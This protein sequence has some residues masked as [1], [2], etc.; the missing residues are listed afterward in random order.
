[1]LM[2]KKTEKYLRKYLY[3]A[4]IVFVAILLFVRS[5]FNQKILTENITSA[6]SSFINFEFFIYLTWSV[7]FLGL[8]IFLKRKFEN[9]FYPF[10]IWNFIFILISFTYN[11]GLDLT[12]EGW[13]LAKSWGFFHGNPIEN[14]DLIWGS[15]FINGLWLLIKHDPSVLWSRIGFLFFIP[16]NGII[17]Y[18]IL[19][20]FHN[21]KT[22]FISTAVSFLFFYRFYLNYSVINYYYLPVFSILISFLFLIKFH[23]NTNSR[24]SVKYLIISAVFS[25]FAIHLKFTFILIVPF[26]IIYLYLFPN[27]NRFRSMLLYYS[28]MFSAVILGFLIL[29]ILGGASEL[30][31]DSTRLSIM[32]MFKTV[33]AQ[34]QVNSSLNYSFKHLMNLYF[35]DIYLIFKELPVIFSAVFICSLTAYRFPR[36]KLFLTLFLGLF[37]SFVVLV[38]QDNHLVSIEIVLSLALLIALFNKNSSRNPTILIF[39]MLSVCALSF[40]GSGLSLFASLISLGF[41]GIAAVTISEL[42]GSRSDIVNFK[43][44]YYSVIILVVATQVFKPYSPY[45][46]LPSSYLN[47]MFKSTELEGIYSFK[48]R[49]DVV[50][51]FMDFAKTENIRS[52]K[53]IFVAMPMFYFLLDV[54]PVISE[55]HDVILGFEQL[56]KEVILAEPDVIVM[57]LQSPRGQLWPLPQNAD[58]WTR[59][60]FERQTAH[61]Y[62]FYKEYLEENNFK[63]IFENTMFVAY[64]KCGEI[65]R[66]NTE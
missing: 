58:F 39:L 52:E 3:H 51:E 56:K 49:V 54:N 20:E 13:Q 38:F 34:G 21:K 45:R 6:E 66:G 15:S 43:T 59:D 35:H 23:K 27:K 22:S 50:D 60:G 33:F 17:I 29:F 24:P 57:P 16:F 7:L 47:T 64:R 8:F 40:I 61:Y 30:T 1:M 44:V 31:T 9:L 18:Y 63:I 10:I 48:E 53:V 41:Y 12:D 19:N 37:L 62:K 14:S 36:F 55:T 2:Y 65:S 5:P 11:L 25:G 28:G 4:L 32:N 42:V 46:D 26:F